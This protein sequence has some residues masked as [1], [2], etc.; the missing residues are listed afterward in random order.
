MSTAQ[1]QRFKFIHWMVNQ[2]A[3]RKAD[4]VEHERLKMYYAD[5]LRGFGRSEK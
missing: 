5:K 3:R 4:K 1:Q 2:N